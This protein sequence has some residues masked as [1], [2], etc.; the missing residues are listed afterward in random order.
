[1]PIVVELSPSE[2]NHV[3]RL[4]KLG[5][6]D[7]VAQLKHVTYHALKRLGVS[8][9]VSLAIPKIPTGSDQF[10]TG[11]IV[12]WINK[13]Q[14]VDTVAVQQVRQIDATLCVRLNG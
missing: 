14:S 1:M 10:D 3:V 4:I 13:V 8:R 12:T 2:L 11:S 5:S 7:R 9:D 6:L